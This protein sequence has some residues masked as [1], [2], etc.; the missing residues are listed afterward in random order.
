MKEA[1]TGMEN[2]VR[3]NAYVTGR[4]YLTDYMKVRDEPFDEPAPAS[5][6]IIVSGFAR[7]ILTVEIEVIATAEA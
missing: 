4:E 5:T 6:L 7:K 3:I 1:V 2:I